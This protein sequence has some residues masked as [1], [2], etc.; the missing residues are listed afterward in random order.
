LVKKEGQ[1]DL[2]KI[3]KMM[4]LKWPQNGGRH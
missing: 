1:K 3:V 2:T 4:K